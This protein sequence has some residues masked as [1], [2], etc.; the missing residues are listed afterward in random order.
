MNKISIY[1]I[2]P[3]C[4]LVSL[5]F[6][7][8]S[9][10]F[11]KG[12]LDSLKKVLSQQEDD[13]RKVDNLLL[14]SRLF[15]QAYEMDSATLYTNLA[16]DLAK[17]V[18]YAKGLGEALYRTALIN[19]RTGDYNTAVDY[20]NRFLQLAT[21]RHDT[22]HLGK[23]FWLRGTLKRETDDHRGA[24]EDYLSSLKI[25]TALNDSGR[26][27]SVYQSLGNL[28]FDLAQFDS[29]AYYYHRTIEYC[30]ATG[31]T[32]GVAIALNQLGKTYFRIPKPD[33]EEARRLV[34]KSIAINK[35][36][37]NLI[38]LAQNYSVL[39]NIALELDQLDTA[40]YYYSKVSSINEEIGNTVGLIHNYNNIAEV[41]EKQGRFDEA[42]VNYDKALS[43][44]REQNMAEGVV[45][46]QQNIADIHA[47]L[48]NYQLA[49]TYYDS[50]LHL[51]YEKRF[52]NRVLNSLINKTNTFADQ[53]RY[54][55]A[56]EYELQSIA[57]S[58]SIFDI[59]KEKLLGELK[60]KYEKEKDQARILFLG[61]QN[62]EKDLKIRLR[63]NQRNAYLYSGISLLLAAI[64]IA[65]YFRQKA[66]K[67]RIIAEQRIDQLEKEK[68]KLAARALAE[69]Q[70]E[71]RKKMARELHDDL[72]VLLSN[73]KV[74]VSMIRE[75]SPGNKELLR[76][77]SQLIDQASGDVQRISNNMMPVSLTQS[78]LLAAT[79]ALIEKVN[80]AENIK[81]EC[82]IIGE[83]KRIRENAGIM[84][85][86]V[87]QE[88]INNTIKHAK[89]RSIMLVIRIS[90]DE[91]EIEYSDD[92][93]GFDV[94]KQFNEKSLGLQSIRSRVDFLSGFLDVTSEP[95]N[96]TRYLLR[97][98]AAE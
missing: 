37:N 23:G 32:T 73:A 46:A 39:A 66:S 30:E 71:E 72:G 7:C 86:R 21:Q 50:S 8:V 90:A 65:L 40:M 20:S 53:G 25:Y 28:Y 57:I 97:I 2:R 43:Y 51:A 95:G 35:E 76:Q 81:A 24:G 98:K 88:M 55:E 17:T 68:M 44:Y 61:K 41:Y 93:I 13:A 16:L 26:L 92:G 10:L 34:R 49:H 19:Y 6:L 54:R 38:T 59:E 87:I 74:Q 96:G 62:L 22:M 85:Y 3:H 84:L 12:E 52:L 64:G 91:I 82:K 75:E 58:D 18:N 4:L 56:F 29:A 36:Y 14:V 69:G 31:H 1:R 67:D 83:R 5:A 9:L 33:Y 77:A 60:L 94:E 11:G 63:T 27:L 47:G 45:V 48:G 89:A 70:E 80:L 79:E 78:G 15:Y 42:L